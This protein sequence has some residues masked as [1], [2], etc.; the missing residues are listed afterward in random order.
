MRCAYEVTQANGKWEVLI[1]EWDLPRGRGCFALGSIPRFGVSFHPSVLDSAAPPGIVSRAV[2]GWQKP[3]G[4]GSFLV[5]ACGG[6]GPTQT[7]AARPTLLCPCLWV[8]RARTPFSRLPSP[9]P[10]KQAKNTP[11]S[12]N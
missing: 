3:R 8:I 7:P 2:R 12:P 1:G 6:G 4:E 10:T 5:S 9:Y 11:D